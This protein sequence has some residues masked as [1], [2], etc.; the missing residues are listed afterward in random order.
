M[1]EHNAMISRAAWFQ[2]NQI[3][4]IRYYLDEESTKI[5]VHSFVSSRLDSF[6]SLLH[7]VPK[8]EV[9]KLQ[10]I[11]NAAAKVI[12]GLKKFD[13]VTPALVNLHWLP[14]ALRIDFKILV[15]VYK[16][17]H[18]LAPAYLRDLIKLRNPGRSLR[19]SKQIS[20]IVPRK[21]NAT[22]G[23]RAF[24]FIGPSLWNR[25]PDDCKDANTVETFKSRVKTHLF[26]LAYDL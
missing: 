7:G 16:S 19:S 15:L 4:R 9:D 13:H 24:S 26:K 1:T 25:L 23:E 8:Y 10:R 11:Q 3:G 22:F 2:L 21:N 17:L 14:I 6:N 20:L 5:L 12:L 18:G